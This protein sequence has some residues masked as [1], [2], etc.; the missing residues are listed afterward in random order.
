[1]KSTRICI[2]GGGGRLWPIQFMKDLTLRAGTNG[3]LVLHDIDHEAA[4]NNV[5]VA[6]R[7][8]AANNR[9]GSF[10]VSAEDDLATALRGA[11]IVVISIEP[12][13]S[14]ARWAD[15]VLPEEYGILQSVG[16]T[17]GPGG[18]I[19]ARRAL[20]LFFEFGRQIAKACPGA[21]VINYTNPLTLCTAAL[22]KAFPTINALGCCHEVFHTQNYLA[23]RASKALSIDVPDRRA[24]SLDLT[25]VNHFTFVTAASYNGVDLLAPLK[26]EVMDEATFP[27]L[28]DVALQRIKDEA[29]FTCDQKIALA[30]LKEFGALGA[31]GDRHLAEFVPY[32]LDRD[33]TL[34]S[35]GV[36]RTPYE[37]RVRQAAEKRAKT[38]SD[39]ELIAQK[40]DEEGVDI[41]AALLGEGVMITNVNVPNVGQVPYLPLGHIVETNAVIDHGRITPIVGSVP[42]L[43]LQ[44]LIRRVS[45]VQELTL[46]G[47]WEGDEE[48][49]FQAFLLDPLNDLSLKDSRDLFRRMILASDDLA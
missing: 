24:I 44:N 2:I 7:I 13:K 15:L 38:F 40:S 27:N 5:E 49:L 39:E 48:L 1:M 18:I 21:W 8:F 35:Y 31:A 3:H 34:H 41:M 47:M 37:W 30:F 12:G 20:P 23:Q 4:V 19:R 25:G 36:V 46:A 6:K 32:F 9:S 28:T 22:Y 42:S 16:D 26:T 11:D 10:T 45:E 43:A 17:T 29:W 33:E 14:E